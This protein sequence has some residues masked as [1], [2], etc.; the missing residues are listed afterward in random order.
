VKSLRLLF[1]AL[2]LLAFCSGCLTT[3]SVPNG[4]DADTTPGHN[5][6]AWVGGK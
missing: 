4:Y 5:G 1:I 6:E 3:P 2:A